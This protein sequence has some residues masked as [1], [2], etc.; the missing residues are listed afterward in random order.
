[1]WAIFHC[2]ARGALVMHTGSEDTSCTRW[3]KDIVHFDIKSPNGKSHYPKFFALRYTHWR[4]VLLGALATDN[5]HRNAP[6]FKVREICFLRWICLTV[7]R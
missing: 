6:V 7:I 2:L 5:E 4:T 1:M 3:D